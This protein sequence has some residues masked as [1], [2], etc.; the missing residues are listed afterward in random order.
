MVDVTTD[1]QSWIFAL[2]LLQRNCVPL[3]TTIKTYH[4]SNTIVYKKRENAKWVFPFRFCSSFWT[5]ENITRA[6]R[7]VKVNQSYENLFT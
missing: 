4:R 2:L 6:T 7:P 3:T 1:L 5:E